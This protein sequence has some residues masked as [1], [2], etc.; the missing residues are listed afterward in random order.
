MESVFSVVEQ[1]Q[2]IEVFALTKAFT[3]DTDP[4]KVNLG[5][6]GGLHKI[7]CF[8]KQNALNNKPHLGDSLQG[9]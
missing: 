3:D 8:M 1:G 2:P 5:A 7:G 9:R 4:N 6:G